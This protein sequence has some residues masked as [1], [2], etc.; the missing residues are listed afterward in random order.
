MEVIISKVRL[1]DITEMVMFKQLVDELMAA[2]VK[3]VKENNERYEKLRFLHEGKR[4]LIKVEVME[5]EINIM[6]DH[7]NKTVYVV[8]D[9]Y[10]EKFFKNYHDSKKIMQR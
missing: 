3:Q 10:A 7:E 2:I 8:P 5:N 4:N 9:E 1:N 6:A